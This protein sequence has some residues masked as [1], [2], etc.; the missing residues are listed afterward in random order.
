M[1]KQT[2]TDL[3][4]VVTSNNSKRP[5]I[6]E[7]ITLFKFPP[8]KWITFRIFGPIFTYGGYW[9][10]TKTKE[11]KKTQ[12][13][14]PCPSYDPSTGTRDST[15]YDPW[16]DLEAKQSD[17]ERDDRSLNFAVAGF[18]NAILRQAQRDKPAK[19]ARHTAGEN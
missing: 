19:V 7:T 8:K 17:M 14:T 6:D 16:R 15:K 11:G 3:D 13:Y 4:S 10:K 12:F 1:A 5:R 9:V 18:T 2:G